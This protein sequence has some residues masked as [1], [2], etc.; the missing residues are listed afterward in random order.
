MNALTLSSLTL[1]SSLGTGL[2]AHVDALRGR[3]SG[4]TPCNFETARLETW[5]GSVPDE[6]LAPIRD[7]L[8]MFD[9]RNNRLAQLALAQDGFESAVEQARRRYGARRVGLFLGTSTSGILQTELAYRRRDARTGA[10]PADFDYAATHNT[11]SLGQFVQR[12]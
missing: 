7:E 9:C 10:L 12:H 11:F 3:C 6:Q 5:I 1:T 8:A 4:L 2:R